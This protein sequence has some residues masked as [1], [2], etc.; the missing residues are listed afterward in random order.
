MERNAAVFF[1][2]SLRA[3]ILLLTLLATLAPA[4][5]VGVYQ[6]NHRS[7]EVEKA[8]QGLAALA[9]YAAEN[10][11][12]KVKGTVQLLH[13][14]SRA[15]DLDTSDKAACS[16]FL[17]NVLRRYPQ[18]T[19]LLTITPDGDLHCDS[20]R[21]GRKLNLTTRDYF[22]QVV[23]S[24][25][26][27]FDVVIGG[28]T[29]IAVL[30]VAYPVLDPQG[31][32]NHVLLASLNLSQYAQGVVAA[33]QYPSIR[34]LIW[35]RKGSL[36]ARKPDG[37]NVEFLGKDFSASELFR[38]ARQGEAGAEAEVP[39]L[40]GA[41]R[42][43]ALGVMPGP[44][45][46]GARIT[47]GLPRDVLTADA[48]KGL[49]DALAALLVVSLLAFACAW[50]LAE[51]SIRRP[52]RRI[53]SVASR[54]G[55]GELDARIGA[56]YPR[57]EL[58]ELMAVIDRTAGAVQMQRKE[59]ET[60]SG[61]LRRANR[62]LRVLSSIN[63]LIV[64][65]K[66]RD[67]LFQEACQIAVTVGKFSMG[68]IGMVNLGTQ[69]L[70]LVASAGAKPEHLE[71]IKAKADDALRQRKVL[72]SND[73]LNDPAIQLK[74]QHLQS[75][76]RSLAMLPLIVSSE[77]AGVLV[78]HSAE[79]GFFDEEEMKLLRELAGDIAFA[80]DHLGKAER[81]DYLAYYD[82]LTGLANR[83]LFH[84]RLAQ[85][86]SAADSERPLAVVVIDVE[87]FKVINDT[88]GRQA[89]DSLLKQIAERMAH[90]VSDSGWL[91]RIGAD[92]FAVLVPNSGSAEEFAR[93]TETRMQEFFGEPYNVGDSALRISAKAG[94]AMYPHDGTDAE[95]L[96]RNA[97][98]ALKKAKATGDSTLFYAQ[99][100]GARISGKL[101]LENKLR[102]GLENDEFVLYYQP[103][104]DV[105]SREIMSVEA[106]IRW[107]S[108]ER[109]LVPP[110][111]FIPLLEETGLI[112]EVGS[113]ALKRA[114]LDHRGW[115]EA[116]LRAPRVSVNVSLIQLRQRDFVR[117]VEQAIM[118]G[119]APVGI[120]LEIT[121]S[122][123]MEDVQA[124]VDKLNAIR[125]LGLS[126][127]ID[128]FG[129]GYSSLAYLARLP[130]ATLKI[131]RA[132]ITKVAEEAD[133]AT[134]V[135]T[136]ISLAHSLRLKVVAEGV[137][138]EEQAKMLRL[139]S[140]DQMQ[141]YL[142][143]KPLPLEQM[144]ALLVQATGRVA[145]ASPESQLSV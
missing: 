94:I 144:T 120:D 90:H 3:R 52:V 83:T 7:H 9:K 80:L 22:R 48:D 6:I 100:M 134:L 51:T 53:A 41:P 129:T 143:S 74:D 133:A 119:V 73:V 99:E 30:Q 59:I 38:F 39:D 2:V 20:L 81:L 12:D 4:S 35:D 122:L 113:W 63:S 125:A 18:Y 106:L 13:G 64:R 50:Y 103:K 104:V 23:A 5:V 96:F 25:Q 14:L 85:Q 82:A 126:I 71:F 55:A 124:N 91:A 42:I 44:G 84:D 101:A 98:A 70:E 108:P 32:L 137:E 116:R 46:G 45:S 15:P 61:D 121:E 29:G 95:T 130:V 11:D 43:W 89:G 105:Q 93:R 109:G 47:L 112:L 24:R 68:W 123:I 111:E 79:P 16:E 136:M 26:P 139:L 65:V 87:R 142:I 21:S 138:T 115:V 75:G 54:V 117:N 49:R 145:L 27:A 131:D 33:S 77:A 107:R 36:M 31:G 86:V 135:R 72:I 40:D 60:R 57:G 62:V 69:K 97:E 17:A 76:T 28:L 10:L 1:S 67:E 56:P 140:C 110:A 78:L 127:A 34:M 132:F 58:G 37:D 118:E 114:A 92:H 8:K 128:D 102:Q 66:G 88:L 141:G 19:G